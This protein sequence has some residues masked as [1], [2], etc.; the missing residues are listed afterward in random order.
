MLDCPDD[1][2]IARLTKR[3]EQSGRVDDDPTV[4]PRRI[5]TYY[6]ETAPVLNHYEEEGLL[7]RINGNQPVE[8]VH[9]EFVAKLRQFWTF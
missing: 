2:L 7:V 6:N 5:Q 9:E 3:A 8:T 1:V 4:I